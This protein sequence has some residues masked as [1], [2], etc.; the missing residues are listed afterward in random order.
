MRIKQLVGLGGCM[1]MLFCTSATAAPTGP[2]DSVTGHALG[3]SGFFGDIRIDVRSGPHGENPS[4]TVFFRIDGDNGSDPFGGPVTCLSVRRNRAT[5]A[6]PTSLFPNPIG[7]QIVDN[8]GTGKPD[9]FDAITTR[10]GPTD[11]S[12]FATG[13]LTAIVSGDLRV[14]D[15]LPGPFLTLPCRQQR[16]NVSFTTASCRR[17]LRP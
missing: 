12:P 5:M 14:T 15:A 9:T 17:T 2:Q 11:C 6:V 8:A 16:A 3:G 7:V 10:E 1:A 13:Q 4:G